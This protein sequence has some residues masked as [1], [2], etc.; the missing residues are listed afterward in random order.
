MKLRT[1][2]AAATLVLALFLF[3]Q[4]QPAT[5]PQPVFSG[6]V[7]LT[8]PLSER[9]PN[10]EGTA[11]SPFEAR[12]LGRID[13]DGYFS[14]HISL[15]EH[16]STHLDAPAHF[17]PGAWTVEQIPAERLVASLVVLDVAAKSQANADYAVTVEDIAAW[18]QAHGPVPPGA[19]VLAR[20]GWSARWDSM[21]RYRNPD[22]KGAMHFPGYSPDAA[23]F[24][25]ET[26]GVTAL[27]I[28]TMSVDVGASSDWPVHHYLASRNIYALENVAN[29]EN[30]PAAGGLLMVGPAKLAGGSGAPVRLIAL[31]R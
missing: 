26:R 11:K 4:R 30:A 27:G 8:H 31:V 6:V 10:W 19:V 13:K 17:A 2:I 25:A 20:T 7:D 23:R 24:L 3:A 1:F 5:P 29:L 18:E 22:P 12:A 16:F 9:S 28:D 14:R 21:Q 15:P